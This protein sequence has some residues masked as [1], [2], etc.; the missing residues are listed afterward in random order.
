MI[1]REQAQVL[2]RSA[3]V[4]AVRR[5]LPD[6]GGVWIVGGAVRDALLGEEVRDLDLAVAGDP[7]PPARAIAAELGGHAVELSAEFGTW[8][9][10]SRDRGW[11]VALAARRGESIEQDLAARDFTIGAVAVPLHAGP[12]LDP[13]AGLADLEA[14][15]LREVGERSFLD[16]PLR[17][18]R[19]A[20]LAAQ[21]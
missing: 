11:Q 21:L 19:A 5:A 15:L 16:D 18:L 7:E 3:L 12:A 14:R 8:R 9:V 17:L 1:E 2:R 6:A 4:E 20:R 13:H 10:V